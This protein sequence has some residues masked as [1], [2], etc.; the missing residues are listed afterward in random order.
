MSVTG[1]TIYNSTVPLMVGGDTYSSPSSFMNGYIDDLRITKGIARYTTDFTPPTTELPAITGAKWRDS[2]TGKTITPYGNAVISATQSKFGGCSAYFDGSG[3]YLIIPFS[4]DFNF[5][6]ADFAIEAWVYQ[7]TQAD[8]RTIVSKNPTD[9]SGVWRLIIGASGYLS[10]GYLNASTWTS[11]N[12]AGAVPISTWTHVAVTRQGSSLRL[13]VNGSLSSINA[14]A[15]LSIPDLSNN[16]YV[17]EVETTNT[18]QF[19]GYIED[20]RITKGIARY[21]TNFTP[22]NAAFYEVLQTYGQQNAMI[23]DHL[24][25]V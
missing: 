21:T 16:L 20:L 15:T 23:Y 17:G 5:G 14:S 22:P 1:A 4:A 19:N 10:F 8:W 7:N 12:A 18:W 3:D 9:T 6:S 25:P 24:T 2:A 13:F 11:V